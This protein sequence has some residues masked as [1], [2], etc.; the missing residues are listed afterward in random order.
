MAVLL[1]RGV[2]LGGH[3][4]RGRQTERAYLYIPR[5]TNNSDLIPVR[6]RVLFHIESTKML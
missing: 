5:G 4:W 1:L 6:E 2:G 3:L